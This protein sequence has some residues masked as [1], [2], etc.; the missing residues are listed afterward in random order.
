M[1]TDWGTLPVVSIEDLIALKKTRRLYDYE[2]ISNLV[3]IRLAQSDRPSR[4]LL[5]WASRESFRAEDRVDYAGRL[6]RTIPASEAR[7]QV[8]R[9]IPRWQE[10]DVAYWR[11][12]IRE[13]RELR[14]R[15]MLLPQGA[16][17][18]PPSRG[19]R[20]S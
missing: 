4:T 8:A 11:P 14:G 16:E 17:V 6:G 10:K 2:V 13:L 5:A 12:I 1:K 7:R 20:H 3:Q 9:E 19:R 15:E 18:A